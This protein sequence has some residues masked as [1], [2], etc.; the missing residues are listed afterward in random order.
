M[1]ASVIA[2][3]IALAAA[4]AATGD[5]YYL[6]DGGKI[7]GRGVEHGD[8]VVI[9]VPLGSIRVAKADIARVV[10]KASILDLYEQRRAAAPRTAT[11][12][13]D[14]ARWCESSGLRNQARTHLQEVIALDPDHAAARKALGYRRAGQRWLTEDEYHRWQGD[15]RFRGKWM[16][17]E[18]VAAI[19]QAEAAQAQLAARQAARQGQNAGQNAGQGAGQ[20]AGNGGQAGPGGQPGGGNAGQG[21]IVGGPPPGGRPPLKLTGSIRPSQKFLDKYF[22]TNPLIQGTAGARTYYGDGLVYADGVE[23]GV[24][25]GPVF[26][27]PYPYDGW[28]GS[29]PASTGVIVQT[30]GGY[31]HGGSYYHRGGHYGHHGGR[32]FGGYGNRYGYAGRGRGHG[33]GGLSLGWSLNRGNFRLGGR[34]NASRGNGFESVG[35]SLFGSWRNSSGTRGL[36]FRFR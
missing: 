19:L 8:T 9:H 23:R 15:I 18:T 28:G 4:S 7:E 34:L 12:R 1:R 24:V 36:R 14:L 20:G 2:L 22:V 26:Y 30:Y 11:A 25:G 3:A 33:G 5:V 6:K 10:R 29:G 35:H 31:Y 21:G 13:Y 32:Y 17:P 27:G 16:P